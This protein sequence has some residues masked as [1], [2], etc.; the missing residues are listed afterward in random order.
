MK[1]KNSGLF[2]ADRLNILKLFFR[3]DVQNL[4]FCTSFILAKFSEK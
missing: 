3:V 4:T 1:S 2:E